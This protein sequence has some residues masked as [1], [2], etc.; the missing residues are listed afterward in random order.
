MI[1]NF[2]DKNN[3][4]YKENY[5]LKNA[6]TYRLD[7]KCL[8][9]VLPKN[10]QEL[11]SI[12]REIKNNHLKYLIL[13]N[14]SN[15]IFKNNY[16][17]GVVIKLDYFKQISFKGNIV[18]VGAGYSLI[19]LANEC[20][21]K[22]LSGLTFATSIPGCVGASVAM[23]AG[24]YNCEISEVVKS[25]KVLTPDLEIINLTKDKLDYRY[26]NSFLKE[27]KDYIVLEVILELKNGNITEM[28]EIA[29]ER[30]KKRILTQPLDMPSAG[31][32]FRNPDGMYAGEL[33]EKINLKGTK[34]GGAEVSTKH[35]NFIVNTGNATGRDIILLI[36]TIKKR[37]K[38]EYN[39]ELKL[40]QIVIE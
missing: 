35:A 23:N 12:I 22:G 2:F 17:N 24:A 18:R 21:E 37:V 34:I 25:V 27:N 39:I 33:I 29:S 15:I 40:E 10:E 9:F 14:G 13:A 20:I 8:F 6:N 1:K 28:K 5:P 16:Y 4:E 36:E 38:E 30:R 32:V 11:I 3:I 26:R 19:K 31:S 7:V